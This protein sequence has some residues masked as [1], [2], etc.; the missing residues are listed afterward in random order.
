[1]PVLQTALETVRDLRA[2]C[3]CVV[4]CVLIAD[5]ARNALHF[6]ADSCFR[7]PLRRSSHDQRRT[8][9]G[10]FKTLAA[11]KLPGLFPRVGSVLRRELERF[12]RIVPK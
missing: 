9:L 3:E 1:V 4:C 11:L 7:T 5:D 10:V 12:V 8:V 2:V 6:G